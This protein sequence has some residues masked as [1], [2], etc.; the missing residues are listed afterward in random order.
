MTQI[1]KLIFRLH[2]DQRYNKTNSDCHHRSIVSLISL[3]C[4]RQY[5]RNFGK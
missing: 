3:S 1:I 4:T 2:F 5:S